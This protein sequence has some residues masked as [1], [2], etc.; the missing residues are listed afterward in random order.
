M[1]N[2]KELKKQYKET[3]PQMGVYTI[4][5]HA[6]GKIFVGSSKNLH[7]KS[8]SYRLQLDT[9]THYI[10]ELQKEF[11]QFGGENFT[12][13]V[14]DRLDPKEGPGYDYTDDL[15]TLEEM[16]LEKLQPFGDKGYNKQNS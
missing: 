1:V 14:I 16:W 3:P 12:F 5:N 11:N 2:K 9:G 10:T 8:N 15:K 13:E 7:G 4:T 6:N